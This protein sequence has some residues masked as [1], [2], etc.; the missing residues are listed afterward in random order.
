MGNV[1]LLQNGIYSLRTSFPPPCSGIHNETIFLQ[2]LMHQKRREQVKMILS[3]VLLVFFY[4]YMYREDGIY[5]Y[6][7]LA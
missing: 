1:Y 2:N 4:L 7:R 3:S 6:L 5:K